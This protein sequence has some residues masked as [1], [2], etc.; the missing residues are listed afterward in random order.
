MLPIGFRT[1]VL[2]NNW[3]HFFP[4]Q[5]LSLDDKLRLIQ[6]IFE[7]RKI[8]KAVSRDGNVVSLFTNTD[9]LEAV[10]YTLGKLFAGMSGNIT[11]DTSGYPRLKR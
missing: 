1:S 9:V 7:Y 8:L 3:R 11:V 10:E 4:I 5:G 6:I 2:T